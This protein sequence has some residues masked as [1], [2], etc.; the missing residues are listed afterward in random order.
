MVKTLVIGVLLVASS[1]VAAPVVVEVAARLPVVVPCV[2]WAFSVKTPVL[3]VPVVTSSSVGAPVVATGEKVVVRLPTAG[4]CKA[5][6]PA[7]G[8]VVV[9]ACDVLG[10]HE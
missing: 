7:T 1:T 6:A 4:S 9:I 8:R 5:G 2:A 3:G 10:E